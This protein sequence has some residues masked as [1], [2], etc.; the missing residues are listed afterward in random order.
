MKIDFLADTNFLIYVHEGDKKVLPFLNYNFGVSFI[1]EVELPGFKGISTQEEVK[2]RNL[3]DDC[4]S[5]EW[6]SKIKE[7]TIELRKKYTVKLPDAIIAS[8]SLIYEIPL[9]TADKA[10]SKI[11]ELDLILIEF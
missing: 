3:L 5:V 9:V 6:N 4:F 10:F 7:K 1:S 11:H 2:L 8:T